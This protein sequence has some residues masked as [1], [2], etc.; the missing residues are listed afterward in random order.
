VDKLLF[1]IERTLKVELKIGSVVRLKSGGP[2]MTVTGIGKYGYSDH[3][4]I[5][6]VWFD[7]TKKVEDLFENDALDVVIP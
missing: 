6:C 7:N 2:K 1:S 3:D 4:Q 5:K